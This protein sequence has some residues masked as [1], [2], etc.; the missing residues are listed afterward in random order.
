MSPI[1]LSLIV[2]VAVA[3]LTFLIT[4]ALLSSSHNRR[5]SRLEA[6][7]EGA[8]SENVRLQDELAVTKSDKVRLQGELEG[9]KSE[10]ARLNGELSTEKALRESEA[11][12]SQDKLTATREN[13]ERLLAHAKEDGEK[14]LKDA[15]SNYSKSLSDTQKNYGESLSEARR[16]YE[17]TVADLKEAQKAALDASRNALAVENEKMLKQREE[18]L[19][20]EAEESMKGITESLEKSV[21]EMKDSFE[22]Q[23]KASTEGA[24]SIKTKFD[25]TVEG[26]RRQTEA[27]GHQ[28]GD[29]AR[30]FRGQNKMQGVFGETILENLFKAE[31]L[32]KGRDY[33]AEEYLRD[34]SGNIIRNENTGHMMR[35]DFVLHFPD[36]SDILADSKVSLTALSDYFAATDDAGRKEASKRNLVSVQ[37]HIDELAGKEYQKYSTKGVLN[38]VI[39]FIP[40][41]GAYQ[42]AKQEDPDI[43]AKAFNKNVL[44]TTEET[45]L[46][47]IRLI[48]TAWIQKVQVDNVRKIVD[49]ANKMVERVALYCEENEKV[50]KSLGRTVEMFDKNSER[51]VN[52]RLSIVRAANE[53]IVAGATLPQGKALPSGPDILLSEGSSEQQN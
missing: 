44:I 11:K 4:K 5:L 14:A 7:L 35:P 25:E 6:E 23:K 46:P 17:K 43:F 49:A 21:K 51:L 33:D 34:E 36:G 39:M 47:F 3:A 53:A 29:L 10:N 13:F 27:I 48:R 1:L 18:S 12:A 42:L 41:Y 20:K 15:Q 22:A 24:T 32:Q 45:L 16:N 2:A 37:T 38:Y 19:K 26:L 40:N 30:A 8:K 50:R 28:A 52:G 31:G 9:A